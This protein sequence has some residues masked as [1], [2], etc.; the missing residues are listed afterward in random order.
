MA[1]KNIDIKFNTKADTTGAKQT[2]EAL[3]EVQKAATESGTGAFDSYVKGAK[4]AEKAAQRLKE[5]LGD[6]TSMPDSDPFANAAKD[7][8]REMDALLQKQKELLA[9]SRESMD[10]AGLDDATNKIKELC[11]AY[12]QLFNSR[13]Q[14][15]DPSA[16]VQAV[17]ESGAEQSGIFPD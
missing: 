7:T 5:S 15:A 10:I 17:I 13:G 11:Q 9:A 8:A 4:K 12:D 6:I 3:K 14:V 2:A 16:D 1:E